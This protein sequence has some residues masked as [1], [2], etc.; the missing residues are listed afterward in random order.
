MFESA[1]RHSLRLS[2]VLAALA[3]ALPGVARAE[4]ARP[5]QEQV[6]EIN[7]AIEE[8][9]EPELEQAGQRI[10]ALEGQVEAARSALEEVSRSTGESGQV[11]ERLEARLAAQEQ[12]L[13]ELEQEA[14]EAEARRAE[15]DDTPNMEW[16]TGTGLVW[17]P[18][19]DERVVLGLRGFL[20]ARYD[21]VTRVSNDDRSVVV[22]NFSV[23]ET[24][25]RFMATFADGLFHLA[26]QPSLAMGRPGIQDGYMELRLHP[27]AV[28]RFGQQ[29]VPYD[30]ESNTSPPRLPLNSLGPLAGRFGHARDLGIMLMGTFASRVHYRIGAFNGNGRGNANDN[31]QLLLAAMLRVQ[32]LGTTNGG[33][34]WSDIGHT[35]DPALALRMGFTY[36]RDAMTRELVDGTEQGYTE[37]S[38]QAT[39][40]VL[41]RWRGAAIAAAYYFGADHPEDIE[42]GAE[43]WNYAHGWFLHAGYF[44]WRE[45]LELLFRYT[46][47]DQS[48]E[49]NDDIGYQFDA[50][51]TFFLIGHHARITALYKHRRNLPGMPEDVR[52]HGLQIEMRGWF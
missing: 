51:M 50:G 37:G 49:A 52:D 13:A 10:E 22:N 29:L 2:T 14:E 12:R 8:R 44:V 26:V 47:L 30:W 41:F 1:L 35:Q 48:I 46:S 31:N 32:A 38:L 5:I 3:I 21:L 20:W 7:E 6:A 17:R 42:E 18:A 39:A 33:W 9:V 11:V 40:D 23:P 36:D 43:A 24:R 45:R 19:G 16:S 28:I 34:G 27:A 4:R 25:I 15:E